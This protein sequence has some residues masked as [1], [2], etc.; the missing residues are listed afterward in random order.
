VILIPKRTKT[1]RTGLVVSVVALL[2]V[3]VGAVAVAP[4]ASMMMLARPAVALDQVPSE[5]YS[6]CVK[7]IAAIQAKIPREVAEGDRQSGLT[8]EETC[9]ESIRDASRFHPRTPAEYLHAY[10][11]N[12]VA[13]V[14]DWGGHD[15]TARLLYCGARFLIV[16]LFLMY[17]FETTM[18]RPLRFIWRGSLRT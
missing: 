9:A 5:E 7:F 10:G 1:E 16:G 14:T 11:R 2:A 13:A 6:T 8:P 17:L 18:V 15:W 3:A 12:V 4:D